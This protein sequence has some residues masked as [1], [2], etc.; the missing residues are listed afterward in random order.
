MIS[1]ATGSKIRAIVGV[2]LTC[3]TVIAHAAAAGQV[4]DAMIFGVVTDDTGAVLPGVTVTV[5]GSSLQSKEMTGVTNGKGE[6]RVTPLPLGTYTVDIVLQGF[7]ARRYEAIRL[8][9]GFAAKVDSVLSV[10]AVAESVTVSGVSPV[11]DVKSTT[12][13]TQVTHEILESVPSSRNGV[14]SLLTLGAGTRTLMDNGLLRGTDPLFGAFGQINNAWITVDGV[15]TTAPFSG[16]SGL[17]NNFSYDSIEESNIQTLGGGADSPTSGI[18]LNMI[19]KS[20]SNA[21]HGGVYA[22]TAQWMQSDNVTTQLLA[23]GIPAGTNYLSRWDVGGDI[24]GAIRKDRVWFYG[25]LRMRQEEPTVPGSFYAD[26]SPSTNFSTQKFAI[27]KV[28]VQLTQNQKLIMSGSFQDK[29]RQEGP[30]IFYA[31]ESSFDHD[32]HTELFA[33]EYQVV[34]GNKILSLVAGGF[35]TPTPFAPSLTTISSWIDQVTG[36]AGGNETKAGIKQDIRRWNT[37]GTFTV[38]KPD[39]FMGNH[40]F[41]TGAD[42]TLASADYPTTDVGPAGNYLLVYRSGVPFQININNNPTDP[43]SRLNYLGVYAQDSWSLG[44]RLTLNLGLRYSLDAAY[45]L[46]ECRDAAAAP[47]QNLFPTQCYQENHPVPTYNHFVSRLH[48]A[49]DVTGEG[50]TVIKGGWGRFYTLHGQ[51][52]LNLYNPL[53]NTTTSFRWHAPAGQMGKG[54]EHFVVGQSNLDPNSTDFISQT[55][56]INNNLA[57]LIANPNLQQP[58]SDEL[59]VSLEQQLMADFG[60]RV[61]GVYSKNFNTILISNTLRPYASYNIPITNPDPGPDGKVGTVDDPGKTVTYYDYPASLAGLAFQKPTM[62]NDAKA[63]ASFKSIDITANKRMSKRWQ[64]LGSLTVTKKNIPLVTELTG[65]GGNGSQRGFFSTS[66]NPNAQLF[67]ADNNWEWTSR[68]SGSYNFPA[69]FVVSMNIASY[70][71]TPWARTATFTGGKQI[72][73]I[74]LR[75]EPIGSQRTPVQNLTTLRAE[76]SFR[77]GGG[78]RLNVGYNVIN[79]FNTSY[80]ASTSQSIGLVAQ[81]GATYGYPTAVGNPRVGE[82][83]VKYSF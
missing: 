28:N 15:A 5:S 75:V 50:R 55:L 8:T 69:N 29:R 83:I 80:I 26:G 65:S 64:F 25:A 27:G 35:L 58:G 68:L 36:Y 33:A 3:M 81:S 47:F 37:K 79:L 77:F 34:R 53:A 4:Q 41:K 30:P 63:D 14:M 49:Y 61:T 9:A 23:Q 45:I 67:G 40:E 82:I 71:G 18:Q 39:F 17:N 52:E 60:L 57:N 16:A 48:L 11:V 56:Q 73:S 59:S 76:K 46:A 7:Q 19:L 13:G 1:R 2:A 24:G 54:T 72:P 31:P 10:G 51:D 6:Y 43:H 20:G 62:V 70:S 78:Q 74:A 22:N 12:A 42:L 21:F 32:F 44:H 66:D 38:Y